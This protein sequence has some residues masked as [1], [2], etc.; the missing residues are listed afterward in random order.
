VALSP[1]VPLGTHRIAGVAQSRLVSTVRGTEVA[2]DPTNGLAL[3]AAMRRQ[4]L[5][6]QQ[7]R[8]TQRV[9][10]AASQRVV[11]A[12]TFE[13]DASFAHFELF[14]LITAGRDTGNLIFERERSSSTFASRPTFCTQQPAWR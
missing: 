9:S 1:L 11:R 7:P 12:Q 4:E 8:S 14:R 5:I 10:M 3:E 2:A 13:G 6:R